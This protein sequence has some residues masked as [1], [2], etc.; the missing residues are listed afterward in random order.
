V[1]PRYPARHT[2]FATAARHGLRLDDRPIHEL[3][4]GA[5]PFQLAVRNQLLASTFCTGTPARRRYVCAPDD[6]N[7]NAAALTV[8]P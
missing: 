7:L 8:T 4:T 6:T 5:D 3:H 2:D 1:V